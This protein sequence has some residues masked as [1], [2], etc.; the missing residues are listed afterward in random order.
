MAYLPLRNKYCHIVGR[1]RRKGEVRYAFDPQLVPNSLEV[2]ALVE[3]DLVGDETGTEFLV[4]RVLQV[5][6]ALRFLNKLAQ[7]LLGCSVRKI[8]DGTP[9]LEVLGSVTVLVFGGPFQGGEEGTQRG[10]A[11]LVDEGKAGQRGDGG[12]SGGIDDAHAVIR[13]ESKVTTTG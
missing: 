11:Q 7:R 1:S 3:L 5:P 10:E 4:G 12:S 2:V 6:A 9:D 8:L 13:S